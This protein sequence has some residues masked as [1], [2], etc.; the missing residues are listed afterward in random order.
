[1]R[2]ARS[3]ISISDYVKDS[4]K[5]KYGIES[6]RIYNG[7]NIN[8]YFDDING[9]DQ[10]CFIITG[11]ISETKGQKDAVRAVKRIVEKGYKDVHLDIYGNGDEQLI[12]WIQKYIDSNNLGDIIRLHGFSKD[13]T[14]ARRVASYSVT[15]S[16]NE[17]LGRCTIEAMMAGNFV[18]GTAEGATVEL[19]GERRE[20]GLLYQRGNVEELAEKMIEAISMPDEERYR[21]MKS[22][23]NYAIENFNAEEYVFKLKQIYERAVTEKTG[24]NPIVLSGLE[25]RFLEF[26]KRYEKK[27]IAEQTQI[28]IYERKLADFQ[29]GENEI[30]AIYGTGVGA[31]I[32]YQILKKWNKTE[33]LKM[34]IDNDDMVAQKK[35]FREFQVIKLSEACSSV[36][37]IIISSMDYHETVFK[38]VV[39]YINDKQIKNVKIINLFGHNTD[40]EIREY[41]T[42]LQKSEYNYYKP[43]IQDN[44]AK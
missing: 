43:R 4:F 6:T 5:K 40:S 28:K 42:Y 41:V 30:W 17:A 12:W 29:I 7:F 24:Y 1:M 38:R 35:N 23:Q 25:K 36:D 27:D 22:A 18:I 9:H 16:N 10:K 8:R 44:K 21:T 11:V 19:L 34:I 20:R 2:L 14:E 13:L 37:G 33:V 39:E 15:A 31:R 32:I 26:K 3:I